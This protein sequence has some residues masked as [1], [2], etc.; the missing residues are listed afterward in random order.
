M[1]RSA[2]PRP[3]R[4][5]GRRLLLIAILG[6]GLFVVLTYFWFVAPAAVEVD[7]AGPA[8]AVVVFVGDPDRIRTASELMRRGVA[9]NLVIP[10]GRRGETRTGVCEE[11]EFQ[12]FCPDTETI[13]TRGEAR[14]IG[15]LAEERGWSSLIAVTSD[16]HVHRATYQLKTCHTGPVVAVAVDSDLGRRG[17][18]RKI[19]HE[20]VGT[21]AAMTTQRSC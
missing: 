12:V 18:L 2:V 4:S 20:W 15:Q 3:R 6:L 9:D 7:E 16:Y 13:D 11:T 5:T 10:N 21:I 14:A 17:L 19:A 8:D 1:S